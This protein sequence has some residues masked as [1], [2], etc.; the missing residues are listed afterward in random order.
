MLKSSIVLRGVITRHITGVFFCF[1]GETFALPRKLALEKIPLICGEPIERQACA[2]YG[3]SP[4]FCLSL[5]SL[6]FIITITWTFHLTGSL[7]CS[8]FLTLL[9]FITRGAVLVSLP[10]IWCTFKRFKQQGVSSHGK[11]GKVMEFHYFFFQAWEKSWKLTPD[12][13]KY[14]SHGN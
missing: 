11:P 12:F 14:I 4:G 9:V 10:I 2:I 1:E 6:F 5:M 8:G 3:A 13:G 7:W